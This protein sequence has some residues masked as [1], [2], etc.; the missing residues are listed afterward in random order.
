M[1]DVEL[2]YRE[3]H[4][5]L[6]RQLADRFRDRW[7][8]DEAMGQAWLIAMRYADRLDQDCR[9]WLYVVA[10]NHVIKL[11]QQRARTTELSDLI[12]A[13]TPFDGMTVEDQVH[14]SIR[15][16]RTLAGLGANQ[17][18]ATFLQ[19][20]G[21]SYREIETI[22]GKTNTWV[23]RHVTEGRARARELAAA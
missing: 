2:A 14:A 6:T 8:A 7:L 16:Q 9:G 11:L 10:R 12:V 1:L 19:A 22:C 18:T 17:R 15:L 13:S 5:E 3:H 21:F 20:A 23:N 4:E